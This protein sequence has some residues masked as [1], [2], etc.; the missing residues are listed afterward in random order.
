VDEF[1]D[2]LKVSSRSAVLRLKR[3]EEDLVIPLP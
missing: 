3:G 2:A 1:N